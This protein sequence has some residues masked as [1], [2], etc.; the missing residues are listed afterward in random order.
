MAQ[1]NAY[2]GFNG[3]CREAM[4]FY[5]K[6]LG[7][8]LILMTYGESPMGAQTPAGMKNRIMHSVL[9]SGKISLMAADRMEE[10]AQKHGNTIS[11]C[12]VCENKEEIKALFSRLS[13]GGK[14]EHALKEEFFGTYGELTDKYGFGWMFQFGGN[15]KP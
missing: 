3:N 1:L 12:L 9:T 4:T 7:G 13:A 10:G 15:Q 8:E 6:C 5:S 2:L 14:V 11:L